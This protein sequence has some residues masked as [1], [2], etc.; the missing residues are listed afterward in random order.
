MKSPT[1]TR[2]A[3]RRKQHVTSIHLSGTDVTD[4]ALARLHGHKY[5]R[6][7]H[8]VDAKRVTNAGLSYIENLLQLEWLNLDTVAINDRGLVFLQHMTRLRGLQLMDTFISS[9]GLESLVPLK[10]LE[11][12][13][14]TGT[15]VDDSG[16]R[17]LAK[18]KSLRTLRLSSTRVTDAGV[19]RL[20]S[21]KKLKTLALHDSLVTEDGIAQL[22]QL[23]PE[24]EISWSARQPI[25][26]DP[27]KLPMPLKKSQLAKYPSNP[28]FVPQVQSNWLLYELAHNLSTR[29]NQEL[30][31]NP[32]GPCFITRANFKT[33][34]PAWFELIDW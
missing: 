23:I 34:Q 28:I 12:L 22:T 1:E 14:L 29:I 11:Y 21:L 24:C 32:R 5:L 8:I 26:F 7:L 9:I 31:A 6:E 15:N 27:A 17:I 10:K 2:L 33:S 3:A 20:R 4:N 13:D 19:K 25:K 16:L 30:S 18:L